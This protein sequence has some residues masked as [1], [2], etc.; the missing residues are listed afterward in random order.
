[1][2]ADSS[3]SRDAK[4][5]SQRRIQA[6]FGAQVKLKWATDKAFGIGY[7]S[8][9]K[10]SKAQRQFAKI[11]HNRPASNNYSRSKSGRRDDLGGLFVRSS[12]EANYARYLNFL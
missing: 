3:S 9:R 4:E 2:E 11:A 1:M 5:N 12:W 10:P 8:E 6:Q 7:M